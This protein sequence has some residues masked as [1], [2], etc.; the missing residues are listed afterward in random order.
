MTTSGELSLG[1]A[2]VYAPSASE[3]REMLFR[4][5]RKQGWSQ[6][7]LAAVLGVPKNT[8]RRWEDGSRSPCGSARKLI[9][10]IHTLFFHPAQ[11][12]KDLEETRCWCC[13]T[14]EGR[15]PTV[16]KSATQ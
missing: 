15:S 10:L 12:L 9:W 16:D 6:A 11:L 1:Y 4:L 5:R 2:R 14:R 13:T 7:I 8:L 3:I